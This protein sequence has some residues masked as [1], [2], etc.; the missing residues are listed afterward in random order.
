VSSKFDCENSSSFYEGIVDDKMMLTYGTM[1]KTPQPYEFQGVVD[2]RRNLA[3]RFRVYPYS[4]HAAYKFVISFF[5]FLVF[6]SF[7]F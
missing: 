6:F 1:L 7:L 4:L 2:Y 3:M 5:V